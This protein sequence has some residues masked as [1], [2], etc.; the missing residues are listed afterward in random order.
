MWQPYRQ[1]VAC[2]RTAHGPLAGILCPPSTKRVWHVHIIDRHFLTDVHDG[3]DLRRHFTHCIWCIFSGADLPQRWRSQTDVCHPGAC[4]APSRR[5]GCT[6][7]QTRRPSTGS[8]SG[9]RWR[10]RLTWTRGGPTHSCS[11]VSSQPHWCS[12][13]PLTSFQM[14]ACTPQP[15]TVMGCVHFVVKGKQTLFH[16]VI[17]VAAT[18]AF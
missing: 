18:T 8:S 5:S 6:A 15:A 16:D 2:A 10:S 9:T 14:S 11:W 13:L 4:R 12:E 7:S 1:L 17:K 3:T